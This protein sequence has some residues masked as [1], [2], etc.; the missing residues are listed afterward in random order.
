MI[1]YIP[2]S[3]GS[4]VNDTRYTVHYTQLNEDNSLLRDP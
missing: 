4:Q 3:V 2:F 1:V